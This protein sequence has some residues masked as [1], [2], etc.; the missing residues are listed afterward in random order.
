MEE[1]KQA[2]PEVQ[3]KDLVVELPKPVAGPSHP[4]AGAY[5]P[6]PGGPA[7]Q[8]QYI[9]PVVNPFGP[10]VPFPAIG[11]QDHLRLQARYEVQAHN[12]EQRMAHTRARYQAPVVQQAPPLLPVMPPDP[13]RYRNRRR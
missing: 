9:Q 11:M 5:M 8:P 4:P 13:H 10:N 6:G 3:E 1:Y 2:H 12:I 7:H